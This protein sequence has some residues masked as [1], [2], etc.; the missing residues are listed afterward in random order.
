[1]PQ[2]IWPTR[3][4]TFVLLITLALQSTCIQFHPNCQPFQGDG[5]EIHSYFEFSSTRIDL[6]F[7]SVPQEYNYM[8]ALENII[9]SAQHVAERFTLETTG[10]WFSLLEVQTNYNDKA[11]PLG[12][13]NIGVMDGR[14]DAFS[15]EQRS[16]FS[17][18]RIKFSPF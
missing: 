1:M 5:G 17:G 14:S 11:W 16:S 7:P 12:Q 13:D 18:F 9:P 8:T 10:N 15:F 6:T 3:T 4:S 2:S